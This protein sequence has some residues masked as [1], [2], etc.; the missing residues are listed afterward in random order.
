M[1]FHIGVVGLGYVGLPLSIAF[2]KKYQVIGFDISIKRVRELSTGVDSTNEVDAQLISEA[3]SSAALKL[4]NNFDDLKRCNILIITVPTP[5]DHAKK[6]DLSFIE[7]ASRI[8]GRIL[9]KGDIVIYESTVYPGCTEEICVPI[10]EHES[11]LIFNKDFFVGYSPERINPGDKLNTITSIKKITSGSTP[12]SAEIIDQLYA[13]IIEAGTYRASSIKVAEAAK[14]IENAQRDLNISFVNELALIF[15]RIGI[16]TNEV[17]DAAATKWNF[18]KYKP[19]LVGGHC[20]SVDPYYLVHKAET[21]GYHPEVILSGR[22]VNDYMPIFIANK[23][24]KL[25]LA[26]NIPLKQAKVLVLGFSFK[27]NCPD[28]RNTKVIDVIKELEDYGLY[29]KVCDPWVDALSVRNDYGIDICQEFDIHETFDAVLIAVAH[30]T[31]KAI[32]F[33]VVKKANTIIFDVKGFLCKSLSD[34]RL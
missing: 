11:K 18:I 17:I 21:L 9:K 13:S 28:Y 29:V 32:P 16:D 2:S 27:E 30:D 26:K 3:L 14:A 8:I 34:A 6:P 25:M 12:A 4:T 33:E 5:V 10:L 19:G 1:G 24:I 22:K 7:K 15:D 20:I 23:L 31:F